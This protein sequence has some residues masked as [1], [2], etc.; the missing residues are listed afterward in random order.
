MI[1]ELVPGGVAEAASLLPGDI[2]LGAN[3]VPFRYVDDLQN[4]LMRA[5]GAILTL[6]FNRGG[7]PALR[8]VAVELRRRD[9]SSAA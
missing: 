1:L 6:D 7:R 5:G 2:L 8:H 3:N 4:A 9:L